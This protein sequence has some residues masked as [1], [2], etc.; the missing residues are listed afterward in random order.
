MEMLFATTC[1]SAKHIKY[2][3][4]IVHL[5]HSSPRTTLGW[6]FTPLSS[7]SDQKPKT[8]TCSLPLPM[9]PC[10]SHTQVMQL[11]ILLVSSRVSQA[12]LGSN[13]Q[14]CQG[15]ISPPKIELCA[16]FWEKRGKKKG[17][18]RNV[19]FLWRCRAHR[20]EITK[21]LHFSVH[22]LDLSGLWRPVLCGWRH[23]SALNSQQNLNSV[24]SNVVLL[25]Y[26]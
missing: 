1:Y 18:D 24:L 21:K 22:L 8:Q 2:T 20:N 9:P 5:S 12:V 14:H 6:N 25:K 4:A 11:Q 3:K 19:I 10:P 23:P 26:I 16:S 13:W 17:K 15:Q 7:K